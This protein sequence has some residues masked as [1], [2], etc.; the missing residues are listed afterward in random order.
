MSQPGRSSGYRF[1]FPPPAYC[2][3][4]G[5]AIPVPSNDRRP[6]TATNAYPAALVIPVNAPAA[7][8]IHVEDVEPRKVVT[9]SPYPVSNYRVLPPA[10]PI[11]VEDVPSEPRIS[12][13]FS[14]RYSKR[15]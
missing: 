7:T 12:K 11:H 14:K 8:P 9:T 15:S 6:A 1:I 2:A 4:T 3:Y 5:G 10:M 13:C